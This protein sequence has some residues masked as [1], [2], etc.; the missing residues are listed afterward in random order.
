MNTSE[1]PQWIES[2]IKLR[3]KTVS[4]HE[5][6]GNHLAYYSATDLADKT[7]NMSRFIQLII[8]GKRNIFV[9]VC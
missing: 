2:A 1:I 4:R 8:Y 7:L 5:H 9:L 6:G 3:V